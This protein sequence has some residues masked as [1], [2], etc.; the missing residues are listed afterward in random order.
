LTIRLGR[1]LVDTRSAVLDTPAV[2]PPDVLERAL[3]PV[4]AP[5]TAV[6]AVV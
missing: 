4:V 3:G 5:G 6:L 2:R 1:R